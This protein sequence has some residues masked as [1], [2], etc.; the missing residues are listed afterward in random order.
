MKNGDITIDTKDSE[1]HQVIFQKPVLQK[2]GK[3]KEMG[4]FQDMYHVP[5][6]NQDQINNLNRPITHKEIESLIKSL[7]TNKSLGSD[8]FRTEL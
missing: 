4:N 8:G 7:P 3:F 6:L 2:I 1:N 5:K